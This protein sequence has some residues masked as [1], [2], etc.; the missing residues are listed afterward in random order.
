[1]SPEQ[2]EDLLF[3]SKSKDLRSAFSG[4]DEK[5]R[6][7]LSKTAQSAYSSISR[8]KASKGASER[9]KKFIANRKGDSWTHWNAPINMRA[10][11]ALYA[12]APLSGVKRQNLWIHGQDNQAAMIGILEDRR[13]DWLGEWVQWKLEQEFHHLSFKQVYG[14]IRNG[15]MEKPDTPEYYTFFVNGVDIYLTKNN[16]H[17]VQP[18]DYQPLSTRLRK[19]P[20]LLGDALAVF[21][22]ENRALT[23]DKW[24]TEN[25][26]PKYQ[27]WS[28]ALLDLIE[29]DDLDRDSLLDASL[30]SLSEDLK[31][32]QLSGNHKFHSLLGPT[33]DELAIREKSYRE[34]LIH[35]V[36][37]V[38]KFALAQIVK[39]EKAGQADRKVFLSELPMIFQ[40]A[41]K[42]NAKTA[43]RLAGQIAK[44]DS[45]LRKTVISSIIP[46]LDHEDSGLQEAALKLISQYKGALNTDHKREI[47][48][49]TQFLA[50]SLKPQALALIGKE[51]EED[52]ATVSAEE[53][54]CLRDEVRAVPDDIQELYGLKA[55]LEDGPFTP[56]LISSDFGKLRV[57]HLSEPLSPL[58]DHDELYT[59][60]A[61]A[62]ETI[63]TAS[64]VELIIDAISRLGRNSSPEFL[65]RLDPLLKRLKSGG[66]ETSRGLTRT[67]DALGHAIVDL[68][69]SWITGKI[70][71][72]N[73]NGPYYPHNKA[74]QPMIGH[75]QALAKRISSQSV[76]TRLCTP[77]HSGGWIDP[78][79]W[80]ERAKAVSASGQKSDV[81]DVCYSMLRLE[82]DYRDEAAKS[83]DDLPQPWRAVG[84]FLFGVDDLPNLSVKIHPVVWICAARARDPFAD[85][86]AA[87]SGLR[88]TEAAPDGLH[89]A[90][91]SWKTV[92]S[93]EKPKWSRVPIKTTRYS[94]Q[95]T[96]VELDNTGPHETPKISFMKRLKPKSNLPG[97]A[98]PTACLAMN[99]DSN[100]WSGG[101][102]GW[103]FEWMTLFWPQNPNA[104]YAR[105]TY[106][107]S[108]D[109]NASSWSTGH[110]YLNAL[111]QANRPWGQTG[112]LVIARGLASKNADIRGYIIDA[113]IDGVEHGQFDPE[114]LASILQKMI[115]SDGVKLGRVA[116][117]L[118]RVA[119]VSPLH[120]SLVSM[121]L[122]QLLPKIEKKTHALSTMMELWLETLAASG[123]TAKEED[124]PWLASFKGASKSTKAAKKIMELAFNPALDSAVKAQ[125]LE[126]RLNI[127]PQT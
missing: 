51:A 107:F 38:V 91:Y 110:G 125:A 45:K 41:G 98:I 65:Q 2:F 126:A 119:E 66:T 46:A 24:R 35:P 97:G 115:V 120:A 17:G 64:D 26:H 13:P 80:V 63:E 96:P 72:R 39:L 121:S 43:L 27:S 32:N 54:S 87:L 74:A 92:T 102:S 16:R 10:G 60:I 4:L 116:E 42:G 40:G 90:Q 123:R 28:A 84:R 68:V 83:V 111:F 113:M 122:S 18:N 56:S 94:I 88:L 36:G 86:S 73:F 47:E 114:R 105:A 44:S 127:L 95:A 49:A 77:T 6:K 103:L 52:I 61:K 89:P 23:T 25:A 31:N 15:L 93:E 75:L 82:P 118:T 14:W 7:S 22:Y 33:E 99:L 85:W 108:L 1:M 79:I 109:E 101:A 53:I 29:T 12:V 117:G 78:R 124:L 9:V 67:W 59:A 112:H 62:L 69:Q 19:D 20:V 48:R 57:L 21:K 50:A 5:T 58:Q 76:Q 70:T 104:I 106:A 37:H 30:E 8:N 100:R 55:L 34:L 11:L 3:N 81:P 71:K